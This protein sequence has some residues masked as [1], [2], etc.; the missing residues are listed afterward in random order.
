VKDVC[1][2]TFSSKTAA[3]ARLPELQNGRETKFAGGRTGHGVL[4]KNR[5]EWEGHV[6]ERVYYIKVQRTIEIIPFFI[7]QP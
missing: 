5:H 1:F 6:L 3:K 7:T 4:S 2:G